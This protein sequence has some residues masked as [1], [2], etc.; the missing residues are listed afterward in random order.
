[1]PDISELVSQVEEVVGRKLGR[2][3]VATLKRNILSVFK[4]RAAP[5]FR[6]ALVS[7]YDK[8]T[9]QERSQFG[10][11]VSGKDPSELGRFRGLFINQIEEELQKMRFEGDELVISV[12]DK[13]KWGF[14][15]SGPPRSPSARTV[16]FLVYYIEGITGEFGFITEEHMR[17]M[18]PLSTKRLGRFGEGFLISRQNYKEEGWL[19]RTGITFE[20][21][22]HPISG[23]P[24]FRGF[25]RA[26][27]GFDFGPYV[28]EAVEQTF[29]NLVL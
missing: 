25:E 27:Q 8:L 13:R 20:E 15:R 14:G 21:I 10:P 3:T 28:N 22:K 26:A 4:E 5:A 9:A 29:R 1:M 6:D 18:N 23:Q 24:P 2:R 19:E 16:D 7:E 17:L 12:G 11:L